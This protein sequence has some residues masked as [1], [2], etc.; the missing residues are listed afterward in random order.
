LVAFHRKHGHCNVP[1]DDAVNLQLAQ[2]VATQ[3]KDLKKYNTEKALLSA[4]ETIQY[5]VQKLN[6]LGFDWGFV[7]VSWEERYVS[8]NLL[9]SSNNL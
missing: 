1:D 8:V 7:T 2:W 5:R 9:Y 4:S 3:G 6:E